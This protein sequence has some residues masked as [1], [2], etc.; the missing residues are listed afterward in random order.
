VRPILRMLELGDGAAN[1]FG[2]RK[3]HVEV[4]SI[5]LMVF[6]T[7]PLFGETNTLHL[8]PLIHTATLLSLLGALAL[9]IASFCAHIYSGW[10][11]YKAKRI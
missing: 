1:S 8:I 2:K 10:L 5:T 6:T 11:I 3:V 4:I 7:R 9:A